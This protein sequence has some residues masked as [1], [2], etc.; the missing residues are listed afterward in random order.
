MHQSTVFIQII[1]L[2]TDWASRDYYGDATQK[3][4]LQYIGYK[5]GINES[6]LS[7]KYRENDTVL[8]KPT[9]IN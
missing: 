6:T 7:D 3:M 2:G 5:I 8:M 4:G 9:A 1:P